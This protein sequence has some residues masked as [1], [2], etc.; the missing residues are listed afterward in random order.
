MVSA[1]VRK[2]S[3][4]SFIAFSA[5]CCGDLI[6]TMRARRQGLASLSTQKHV[7]GN[8]KLA[9]KQIDAAP[10]RCRLGAE[11]PGEHDFKLRP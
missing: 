3:L 8:R 10:C 6:E 5:I 9:R 2:P 1:G 11:L 4:V 7:Q